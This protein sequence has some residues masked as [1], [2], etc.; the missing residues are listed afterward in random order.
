MPWPRWESSDM[1]VARGP[2]PCPGPRRNLLLLRLGGDGSPLRLA[3]RRA[4]L[5]DP[6]PLARVLAL[7]LVV[8]RGAGTLPLA[9][10]DPGAP[11]LV[12][13]RLLF[14]SCRDGTR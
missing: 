7:A 13:A 14:R 5:D 10:V 2:E 6:L 11:D 4:R 9:G 1:A 12:R 8:G 3:V